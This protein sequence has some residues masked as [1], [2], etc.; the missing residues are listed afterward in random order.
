MAGW[1]QASLVSPS[2]QAVRMS[3]T[4]CLSAGL[5]PQYSLSR[6]ARVSGGDSQTLWKISSTSAGSGWADCIFQPC[7]RESPVALYGAEGGFGAGDLE[8]VDGFFRA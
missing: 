8:D 3:A 1:V 6:L 7:A 2:S 4:S 5:S